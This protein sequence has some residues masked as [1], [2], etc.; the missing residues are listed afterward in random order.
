MGCKISW[1]D[2]Q[3]QW[4]EL[5]SKK[6]YVQCYLYFS[7]H[8]SHIYKTDHMVSPLYLPSC[9]L[10]SHLSCSTQTLHPIYE[11]CSKTKQQWMDAM[12]AWPFLLFM[13]IFHRYLNSFLFRAALSGYPPLNLSKFRHFS[14]SYC[15]GAFPGVME[16]WSECAK[17]NTK[18]CL[19][20]GIRTGQNRAKSFCL[21]MLK[22][23][24][25]HW[26]F[27]GNS[28]STQTYFK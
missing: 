25:G 4:N 20:T 2:S 14:L 9:N 8:F 10:Y 7:Y 17:G 28:W 15:K 1:E 5:F 3:F 16:T 12:S 11:R 24:M 19:L 6:T 22:L 23:L 18:S 27:S 21:L 13:C 26:L